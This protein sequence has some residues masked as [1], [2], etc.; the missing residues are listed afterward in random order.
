M[1]WYTT[2]DI[3][4]IQNGE[5]SEKMLECINDATAIICYNDQVAR[6]LV[7]LL[8]RLGKKYQ[9]IYLLLALMI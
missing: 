9:M 5:F 3:K 7:D 6:Y 1:F 4:Q 2:E 8:T